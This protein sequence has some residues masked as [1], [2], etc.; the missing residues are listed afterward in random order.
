MPKQ[1]CEIGRHLC[2]LGLQW[3]Q[4][5]KAV[6]P[7]CE[8]Q[9]LLPSF[10]KLANLM[11]LREGQHAVTVCKSVLHES[12]PIPAWW[13][14][15]CSGLW[16]EDG[17]WKIRWAMERGESSHRDF[18]AMRRMRAKLD[19]KVWRKTRCHIARVR[20]IQQLG[21]LVTESGV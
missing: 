5:C 10:Q 4:A 14:S 11:H 21:P 19:H 9:R 18:L 2:Q 6:M 1:E 17:L 8:A 13:K 16:P 15:L 12:L 3:I 20:F 7:D